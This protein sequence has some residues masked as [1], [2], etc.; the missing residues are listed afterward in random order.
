MIPALI[1]FVA[2]GIPALVILAPL[3]LRSLE[4]RHMLD[5][6]MAATEKGQTVPNDLITGLL[7]A[8][9]RDPAVPLPD[10]DQRRGVLLL[11]VAVVFGALGIA[12]YAFC[13]AASLEEGPAAAFVVAS[14]GLIPGVIGAA[15]LLLARMGRRAQA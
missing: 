3:L 9:R 1:I 8:T 12:T 10:R 15:Y 11:A 7:A 13:F 2:L 4:R 5:A 14:L 6:V